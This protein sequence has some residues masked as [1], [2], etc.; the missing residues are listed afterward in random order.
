MD[1]FVQRR[2][3]QGGQHT[4]FGIAIFIEIKLFTFLLLFHAHRV[5][6]YSLIIFN[7]FI[8]NEEF[9]EKNVWSIE[10][11]SLSVEYLQSV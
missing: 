5:F 10:F 3:L 1:I 4:N 8:L 2:R 9:S 6:F 7:I 11:L